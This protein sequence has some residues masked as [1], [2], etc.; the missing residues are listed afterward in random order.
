MT[1]PVSNNPNIY[2][3]SVFEWDALTLASPDGTP[4]GFTAT[5]DKTV[6]VQGTFGAGGTVVLQG[7]L[8]NVNWFTLRDPSG[9]LLSFT[10]SNLRAILEATMS[11]RPLVTGG[12]GS[13]SLTVLVLIRKK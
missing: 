13:T 5:G 4:V 10:S 8:D 7:T 9:N 3:N 12:D 2:D 11:V 6:Q 1:Q